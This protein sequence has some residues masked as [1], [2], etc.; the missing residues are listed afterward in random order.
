[1]ATG[2]KRTPAFPDSQELCPDNPGDPLSDPPGDCPAFLLAALGR[3]GLKEQEEQ[4]TV[5]SG[6]AQHC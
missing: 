4:G 2:G 3:P 1:M 5:F 6:K